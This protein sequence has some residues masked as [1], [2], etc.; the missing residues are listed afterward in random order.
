MKYYHGSFE[1]LSIGLI[2]KS[3]KDE[4]FT[5]EYEEAGLIEAIFERF[6][7]SEMISRT[8]AVYICSTPEMIDNVGGYTDNIFE[9]KPSSQV[10]KSDLSWYTLVASRLCDNFDSNSKVPKDVT[11]M[12]ENYW[13]GVEREGAWEFRCNSAKIVRN[14]DEPIL[15]QKKFK[16]KY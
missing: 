2:L 6:K 9:V 12:V 3:S 10:E 13:N 15:K 11:K 16:M 4:G 14:I 1:D 8:T 7:P 5:S